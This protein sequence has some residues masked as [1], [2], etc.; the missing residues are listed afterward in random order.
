GTQLLAADGSAL[1]AAQDLA[2][3]K[4]LESATLNTTVN[5]FESVSGGTFD[6]NVSLTWAGVSSIGHEMSQF[7]YRFEGCQQK[8]QN[9]GTFRL[10][11]VS[12]SVSDGVTEYLESSFVDAR[13]FSSKGGTI[14]HGCGF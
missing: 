1:L 11:Q 4:K 2:V 13:V 7:H 3:S 6:V 14:I 5:M 9:N 10:A 8:S 12:G